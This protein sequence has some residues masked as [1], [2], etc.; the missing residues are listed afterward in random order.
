[1]RL[2]ELRPA[3][4]CL[5]LALAAC[6]GGEEKAQGKAGRAGQPGQGTPQV[7]YVVAQPTSAA[8]VTELAGRTTAFESSDVRP[9]VTGLIRR[10]FFNS[11]LSPY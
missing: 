8:L 6:G 7:G 3:A 4:V 9:Q 11:R 2:Q 5:A 10:R 1:M